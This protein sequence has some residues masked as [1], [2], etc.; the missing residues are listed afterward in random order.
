MYGHSKTM[1]NDA[2]ERHIIARAD[3]MD[4]APMSCCA[5]KCL[6]SQVQRGRMYM[7]VMDNRIEM[8]QNIGAL[9]SERTRAHA[10]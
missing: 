5:Y 4:F 9:L 3:F 7:H 6:V 8:N 1:G 10:L 2:N